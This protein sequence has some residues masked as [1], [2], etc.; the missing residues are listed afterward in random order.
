MST[1]NSTAASAIA[2]YID[3]ENVAIGVKDA[4]LKPYAGPASWGMRL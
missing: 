4:R 3:L 2:V 1:V